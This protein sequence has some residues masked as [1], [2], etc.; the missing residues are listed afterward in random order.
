MYDLVNLAWLPE[1]D[2]GCVRRHAEIFSDVI[3]R[4]LRRTY[5]MWKKLPTRLA[6]AR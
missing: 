4:T 5:V 1:L 6:S 2:W 3:P